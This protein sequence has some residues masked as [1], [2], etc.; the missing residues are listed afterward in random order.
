MR[1]IDIPELHEQ[2]WFPKRLRDDVTAALQLILNAVRVYQPITSRLG[3][4]LRSAHADRLVDLCSGAGGPWI[5]LHRDV[6]NLNLS[7]NPLD[8]CLTD[9]YP[10]ATA[11]ESARRASKG[12]IQYCATS[13]DAASIPEQFSGFRTIFTSFHHFSVAQAT[14]ILQDAIDNEEGIGIFEAPRRH[15]FSVLLVF[16]TPIAALFAIPFIR[17]FRFSRIFWTYLFPVIPFVL[18]FDGIL[19]CL[20]A[21]S[22]LE[23]SE[24]ISTLGQNKYRWEVGE[25]FGGLVPVTYLLGYPDP[26]VY[27]L[28][29]LKP[30]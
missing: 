26:K 5:W 30:R 2:D 1:R 27:P 23:L 6:T 21:Y 18:W 4:A 11:F 16:F 25:E 12:T 15:V 8:I 20:R 3:N 9:K 29:D 7:L 17:P 22:P 13:L 10:N 28:G 19:S 24:L 14:S